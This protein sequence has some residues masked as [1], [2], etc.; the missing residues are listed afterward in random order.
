MTRIDGFDTP[1]WIADQVAAI[2]SPSGSGRGA[3]VADYAAGN[4]SLLLSVEKLWPDADYLATDID[5]SAVSRLRQS[6]PKWRVGRCDFLSAPSRTRSA[7]VQTQAD[8]VVLNPPFSCRGGRTF[9]I[10]V[11]N[12]TVRCGPAMAFVLLALE[13]VKVG[14]RVAAVLPAS[15]L[16]SEK[17]EDARR[18]LRLN[19]EVAEA[20]S[21][22]RRAFGGAVAHTIL[23]ELERRAS[24]ERPRFRSRARPNAHLA[25]PVTLMPGRVQMHAVSNGAASYPLVHTS[26]LVKGAVN[27]SSRRAQTTRPLRGPA[28]LVP[29][30][31]APSVLKVAIYSSPER[32]ALSDCVIGLACPD[33]ATARS[34]HGLIVKRWTILERQYMGSCAPYLTLAR[35]REFLGRIGVTVSD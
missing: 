4:G 11:F 33:Q 31:G 20:V 7:L 10:T 25:G 12:E 22:D 9:E 32:V 26:Q 23:V 8:V 35:L 30:V 27:L 2:A 19:A 28:V 21:F 29:R 16:T 17:D 34:V 1:D 5:R 3:V 15:A 6:Q 24:I 13:R 14:G 18:V